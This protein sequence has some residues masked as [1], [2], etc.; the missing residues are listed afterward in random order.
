MRHGKDNV[1]SSDIK[2]CPLPNLGP[3]VTIDATDGPAIRK[4]V[5]E[6]EVK[7][8]YLM[9]AM[10]SATGEKFPLQAW[11]LNMQSLIHVL[12]LARENIIDKVFWPSSIAVFGPDTPRVDTPQK[13]IM[14]PGTMYGISKS[15]GELWCRYYH[16]RYGVDVR[17]VRYPGLI[18]YKALPGG[19]TTDYAVHIFHEALAKG[20]YE[21]FLSEGRRLPMMY[22]EDAIKATL[23]I[24][25][26][27]AEQI[28]Q[29]TSYNIAAFSFTPIE[30][31]SAIRTHLPSFEISYAPD[32]RDALAA[33][34]PESIDDS[35][36]RQDWGWDPEYGLGRMVETMLSGIRETAQV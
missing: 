32:E 17:S 11:Q 34:W 7:Q 4:V 6:Y 25:Q 14:E 9:A 31:A 19:G 8:V 22:M 1:I 3:C 12:E 26:A 36:A 20:S 23:D 5:E 18:G 2:P 33:S 15:S 16:Q 29:R 24:M 21:C 35:E 13:T 10:L 30:L 28:K 27:P